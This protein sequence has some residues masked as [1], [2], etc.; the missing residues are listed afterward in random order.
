MQTLTINQ[1]LEIVE[2]QWPGYGQEAL[3]LPVIFSEGRLSFGHKSSQA[4]IRNLQLDNYLELP[5]SAPE[6]Q[7]LRSLDRKA[8]GSLLSSEENFVFERLLEIART[9]GQPLAA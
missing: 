9:H 4:F 2:R 6:V 1:L 8:K 7:Q 5:L 3:N